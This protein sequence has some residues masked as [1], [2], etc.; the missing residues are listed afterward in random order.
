MIDMTI[1][2]MPY[3]W[4]DTLNQIKDEILSNFIY[5]FKKKLMNFNLDLII[6]ELM[7]PNFLE[8][9]FYFLL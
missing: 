1:F 2:L 3:L 9:I 8:N 7:V 5:L 4:T 6:L